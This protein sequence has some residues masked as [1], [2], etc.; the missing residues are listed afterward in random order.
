MYPD[1]ARLTADGRQER[2]IRLNPDQCIHATR[3]PGSGARR[4]RVGAQELARARQ[5]P[6]FAAWEIRLPRSGA[7]HE[8]VA[9]Q[10]ARR[11]FVTAAGNQVV[12]EAAK[13]FVIRQRLGRWAVGFL[14]N[15]TPFFSSLDVRHSVDNFV[16]APEGREHVRNLPLDAFA[17]DTLAVHPS[18]ETALGQP[19]VPP[20][21]HLLRKEF[22]EI[23]AENRVGLPPRERELFDLLQAHPPWTDERGEA[24][25]QFSRAHGISPDPGSVHRWVKKLRRRLE[26][27]AR[28]A[29][30]LADYRQPQPAPARRAAETECGGVPSLWRT[31]P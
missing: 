23:V 5:D 8:L 4:E 17:E 29:E 10:L 20:D 2:R 6:Q 19:S 28:L 14:A 31:P 16:R 7:L 21:L 11:G 13:E 12:L 27:D 9:G 3:P 24:L 30:I 25:R 1:A 26:Q 15:G 18:A 22:L